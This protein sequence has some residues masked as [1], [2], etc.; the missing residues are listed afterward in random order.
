MSIISIAMLKGGLG[1]T[2]TAINLAAA[3]QQMGKK[4]LLV[5]VDPQANMSQA[6]GI[7]EESEKSLFS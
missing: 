7:K 1:K 4:V 6:L 3:L 2:T 5:D